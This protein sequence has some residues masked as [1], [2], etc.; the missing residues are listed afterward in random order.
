M[1]DLC[2]LIFV[3]ISDTIDQAQ[4]HGFPELHSIHNGPAGR[5]LPFLTSEC[6]LPCEILLID[7]VTRFISALLVGW[8]S[9]P[10]RTSEEKVITVI[11]IFC[12]MVSDLITYQQTALQIRGE[13]ALLITFT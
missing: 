1:Y 7:I 9:H 4:A 8:L 11:I 13:N 5:G 6:S 3:F 2:D 12:S 10:A